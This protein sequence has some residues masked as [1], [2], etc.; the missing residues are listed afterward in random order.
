MRLTEAL[1]WYNNKG[2]AT[3]THFEPTAA[4]IKLRKKYKKRPKKSERRKR[5]KVKDIFG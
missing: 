1:H 2:T 5:M 4:D 3:F